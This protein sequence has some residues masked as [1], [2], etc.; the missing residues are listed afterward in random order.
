[1]TDKRKWFDPILFAPPI[2]VC[3]F[4]EESP[5]FV[6]WFNSH[7]NPDITAGS[8]WRVNFTGLAI[9][10]FVTAVA[11]FERGG[12]GH[13]LVVAWL[14][15]L[16]LANGVFHIAAAVV[17]RGYV[18]GV[19]TSIVLYLPYFSWMFVRAVKSRNVSVLVLVVAAIVGATPMAVH[20]Y[21]IVFR[22]SRLF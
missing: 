17:D 7:V 8:F 6:A 20:G 9:T 14:G 15:M 16:M 12:V 22:G 13:V 3:H 18:P 4:L 11:W 5:T 19:V 10:L 1:M 21:L 2:F